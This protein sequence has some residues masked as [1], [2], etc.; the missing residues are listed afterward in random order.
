MPT[1]EI[2]HE[3]VSPN[4]AE[5]LQVDP[6]HA[7]IAEV[8]PLNNADTVLSTPA[9]TLVPVTPEPAAQDH[10]HPVHPGPMSVKR[11]FPT[12]SVVDTT[13]KEAVTGLWRKGTAE[14]M[15][16]HYGEA[17]PAKEPRTRLGKF[18]VRIANP[19]EDKPGK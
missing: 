4:P 1:Q 10:E 17:V 5:T 11:T 2:L 18:L 14:D 9:E 19:P 16:A 7:S 6:G 8:Q 13:G 3:P 12:Y 15:A